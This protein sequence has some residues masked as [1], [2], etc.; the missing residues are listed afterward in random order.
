MARKWWLGLVATSA[1]LPALASGNEGPTTLEVVPGT[2]TYINVSSRMVNEVIVP[3]V[4]PRVVQF[5]RSDTTASITRDGMS[6]Y[7]ATGHEEFLQLIIKDGD[8]P[9]EPGISLTLIPVDDIPPQHIRLQPVGGSTTHPNGASR[10]RTERLESADYEDMLRELLRD[11]AR[12]EVP[13]GYTVDANWGGT[14][15]SVGGVVGKSSMRLIGTSLAIE[16]FTLRNT[17]SEAVE[18]VEQ[19]FATR[20]VRAIAFID[21][22]M[23]GPGATTRMVWVADKSSTSR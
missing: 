18:L 7:V 15:L 8:R 14:R 9:D 10:G 1:L 2:S 13:S 11:A 16:Y 4:S 21:N 6:I 19:N 23:L 3:F 20:G 22:V 17:G 12:D 5:L